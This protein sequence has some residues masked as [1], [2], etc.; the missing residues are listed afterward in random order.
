MRWVRVRAKDVEIYGHTWTWVK[1]VVGSQKLLKEPLVGGA[2][3]RVWVRVKLYVLSF[4]LYIINENVVH[5]SRTTSQHY[6]IEGVK[7]KKQKV[8]K[9]QWERNLWPQTKPNQEMSKTLCD[10]F[11]RTQSEKDVVPKALSYLS[12]QCSYIISNVWNIQSFC[13]I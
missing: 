10:K 3:A 11:L 2:C 9:I 5:N 8:S 6:V 12:L 7:T 1:F 4:S 13:G